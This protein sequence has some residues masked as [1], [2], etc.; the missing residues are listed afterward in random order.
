MLC[1]CV[2]VGI[3]IFEGALAFIARGGITY[4]QCRLKKLM[5]TGIN[6]ADGSG[7][8]QSRLSSCLHRYNNRNFGLI[9]SANWSVINNHEIYCK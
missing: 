4:K 3:F 6:S 1:V 8:S 5:L 2:C 9:F 7:D